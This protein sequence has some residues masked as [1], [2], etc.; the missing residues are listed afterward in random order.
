MINNSSK[1]V[2]I[3][4]A[5]PSGLSQLMAFVTAEKNGAEIPELVCYEKQGDWGGLWNYTWRTG[6]DE[7][8]EPVHGSMYQYL[9]SNGPKECLEFADYPFDEHFGKPIPSFPPRAV[10]YD[11]ITGR[12]QKNDLRKYIQF[13]TAVKWVSYDEASHKFQVVT[14]CFDDNSTSFGDFDNVV[15]ATGHFSTPN[16]PYFEGIESFPGRVMHAHDFRSADE[17]AGKD[18][19]VVGG[20]YSAEDIAL[21]CHKYGANSVTISYRTAAMDFKWPETMDERSLLT[22]IDGRTIHF[23]D[24]SSKEF[25]AV[26]LC[27]GYKHHFPFMEESLRLRCPNILYPEGLYKGVVWNDNPGVMY[28]SMQ[29]QWYTFSHF[30]LMA[31]FARDV[32]MGTTELPDKAARTADIAAWR[33]REDALEDAY[34]MIDFQADH[35]RDLAQ[36]TDYPS[37]DI[38]L[39]AKEFKQWKGHKSRDITTYR[40]EP[41]ESP[42]TGTM[43]AV[44]HTTWLEAMD[45]SMEAFM[46]EK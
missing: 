37:F 14:E 17:F 29:D 16:V 27:T 46:A 34:G 2:A 25:D 30:D 21:Q 11:Y 22:R 15:V 20:S 33:A 39:T 32:I 8:S 40:N 35:L 5:G 13:N 19:L 36:T 44:H 45:D 43:A 12:A 1:R 18:V 23:S 7:N 9:W 24:D 6:M 42:V 26:L 4:G 10:L 3:I 31:W 28:L 41:F 38:D